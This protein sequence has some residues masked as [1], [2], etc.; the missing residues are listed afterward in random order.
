MNAEPWPKVKN[1][2]DVKALTDINADAV[3]LVSS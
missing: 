3:L 1:Q 2:S